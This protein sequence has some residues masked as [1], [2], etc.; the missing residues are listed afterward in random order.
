MTKLHWGWASFGIKTFSPLLLLLFTVREARIQ[1]SSPRVGKVTTHCHESVERDGVVTRHK[2]CRLLH[3]GGPGF[4]N[5][6]IK[7]L[8]FGKELFCGVCLFVYSSTN[9]LRQMCSGKR[10]SK[11]GMSKG[12]GILSHFQYFILDLVS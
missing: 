11:F 10:F 8:V 6:K 5:R 7:I 3:L 12:S 9:R 1:T 4:L 2:T